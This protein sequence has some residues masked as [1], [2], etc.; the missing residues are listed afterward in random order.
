MLGCHFFSARLLQAFASKTESVGE[1]ALEELG[2]QKFDAKDGIKSQN[3]L[4]DA[5]YERAWSLAESV[6]LKHGMPVWYIEFI[7][8]SYLTTKSYGAQ[9]V[10]SLRAPTD[11]PR[12]TTMN[13]IS[14]I[15]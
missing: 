15:S 1:R 5:P 9:N 2:M 11:G 8:E 12:N 10:V 4:H 14:G 13:I 7:K 6:S 3:K